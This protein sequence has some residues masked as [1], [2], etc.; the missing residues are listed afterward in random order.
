[1]D[2]AVSAALEQAPRLLSM[3]QR[4]GRLRYFTYTL[5]AMMACIGLLIGVYLLALMLPPAAGRLVSNVIFIGVKSFGIPLIIVILTIRRLHDMNASGWWALTVV[6]PFV[7]LLFLAIRGTPGANR[8]GPPPA[9]NH[10]G[11][12][13]AALAIPIFFVGSYVGL[14]RH[15]TPQVQEASHAADAP[16]RPHSPGLKPYGP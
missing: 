2:S 7:T 15:Q 14:Y 9:P 11:L 6:V 12:H 13:F 1:M 5:L 10:G 3:S 16:P 4:I 8:F